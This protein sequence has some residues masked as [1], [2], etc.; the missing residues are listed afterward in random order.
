MRNLLISLTFIFTLILF[1]STDVYSQIDPTN[2][3]NGS[4]VDVFTRTFEVPDINISNIDN[5]NDN[6]NRPKILVQISEGKNGDP[7][8]ERE[9]NYSF[10]NSS[11]IP[12]PAD[13]SAELDGEYYIRVFLNGVFLGGAYV[14]F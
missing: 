6:N 2:R 12:I 5:V 1:N 4:M 11:I 8:I 9:F 13:I 3:G 14:E 7:I 10:L